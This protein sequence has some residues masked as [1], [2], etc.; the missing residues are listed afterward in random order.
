VGDE[1][2]GVPG[3]LSAVEAGAVLGLPADVVRALADAGYLAP[4]SMRGGVPRFALGDLKAF[5]ARA[6]EPDVLA[7]DDLLEVFDPDAV[8]PLLDARADDI[9]QRT[10][11]LLGAVL[12]EVLQ[13]TD[14]Q[15]QR[16]IDEAGERIRAILTVCAHGPRTDWELERDLAEIGADAALRGVPLPG[17]LIV[18]RT[19]RDL[20]VQTAV[21]LA[22]E[23]GRQWGLALSVALTR[24]LPAID[25]LSDA[26]ARGYWDALLEIEVEAIDRFRNVADRVA[27][28]VFALDADGLVSY[29]NPVLGAVL[30][31][32]AAGIVGRPVAEVLGIEAGVDATT[33]RFE[34]RQIERLR[35]GVVVGW[36]GVVSVG[37]GG[38]DRGQHPGAATGVVDERDRLGDDALGDGSE[39][40]GG[41]AAVEHGGSPVIAAEGD[42]G[43]ERHLPE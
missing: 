5:Q 19:S 4:S 22:E 12:P 28:G 14:E 13:F 24:V 1:H 37:E 27:D 25:R 36:D 15:R 6:G 21:E 7:V 29:A 41:R 39:R 42:G 18:L 26:V 38:L 43:L 40:V 32:D 31:V 35:D 8:L 11:D 9:A 33:S 2:E 10:F 30:G 3:A 23:R 34:V 17:V 20:V 16:F